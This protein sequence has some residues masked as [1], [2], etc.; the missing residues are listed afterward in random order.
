MVIYGEQTGRRCHLALLASGGEASRGGEGLA[1]FHF[2]RLP[3][4]LPLP[5]HCPGPRVQ[6]VTVHMIISVHVS[7]FRSSK[8][9]WCRKEV[10]G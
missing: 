5:H 6:I 7:K 10:K 2:L 8:I 1:S 9:T 3:H 4:N